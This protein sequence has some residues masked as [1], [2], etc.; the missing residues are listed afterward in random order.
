MKSNEQ[1]SSLLVLLAA[2]LW[3][4]TGTSQ[5]LAPAGVSPLS[6][7][8]VRLVIGGLTLLTLALW[9]RKL[10]LSMLRLRST[11]ISAVSIAAYQ[12]LFFAGVRLTGVAVGTIVTIGSSPIFAG[13]M[14][15]LHSG[16]R[17]ARRWINATI[18]CIVGAA[19]LVGG[20]GGSLTLN[21]QGLLMCLGAGLSYAAYAASSKELLITYPPEGVTGIVFSAGGLLLLP[22]L[23]IWPPV[24]LTSLQG[25]TVALY[26]GVVATALAYI[27]FTA[28]L[29]NIPFP[30]A[31]TLTLAE[32]LVAA[33]LGLLLLGEPA[34]GASLAGLVLVFSG[35]LLLTFQGKHPQTES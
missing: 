3:G 7:G 31:V 18:L 4:T 5:A 16:E 17:P 8:T 12:L 9:R 22:L 28:G 2:V 1:F 29:V 25:L 33:L 11:W 30:R 23:V 27:L 32:P 15:W 34:T 24:W 14:A 20:G 19:F 10:D 6:I 21:A 35:L 13:L 26:L